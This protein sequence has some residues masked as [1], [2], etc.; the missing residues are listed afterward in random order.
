MDVVKVGKDAVKFTENFLKDGNFT[1]YSRLA[2]AM[3]RSAKDRDYAMVMN[4]AGQDLGTNSSATDWP[5][6][7]ARAPISP[8]SMPTKGIENSWWRRLRQ[9]EVD[10]KKDKL[11]AWAY[12]SGTVQ[13]RSTPCL[14]LAKWTN[15]MS[16]S[17]GPIYLY[18]LDTRNVQP[19]G[20]LKAGLTVH[21]V[22]G[23]TPDKAQVRFTSSSGQVYEG[24]ARFIDLGI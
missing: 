4:G 2:D 3:G 16:C 19:M 5:A 21:V 1:V 8:I 13:S 15:R 18:P 23:A 12:A 14:L 11:G 7:M 6:S 9:A 17:P 22:K 20:Q 24:L 10:A